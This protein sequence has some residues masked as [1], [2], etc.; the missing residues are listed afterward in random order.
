M[1]SL[2]RKSLWTLAVLLA[3]PAL[4][5]S[6]DA[7]REGP[8]SIQDNSFLVE[9]AYNQPPGVVQH[10]SA[11][12][13]DRKTQSW[14]YTFTQEWPVFSQLH[15]LSYTIP[16]ERP[17]SRLG[18]GFGDIA[19]NYR[20]QMPTGRYAA[21]A[22]APRLSALVPTGAVARG[23]GAGGTGFQANLPVSVLLT[24]SIASHSNVGMTYTHRA[25]NLA[26]ARSATRDF[27]IGQ[28]LI[29]LARPTLNFMLEAAWDSAEEVIDAGRRERSRGLFLSP[30]VR[31]A[32]NLKSGLQIV[33]G[34]AVPIGIG[35]SR[36]ERSM[37][38][39]L[40]FEHPFASTAQKD[41]E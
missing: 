29:W 3:G 13:L 25:E 34:I 10:I 7:P 19:L 8:P 23:R 41:K 6:P 40:S 18:T 14:A 31:G 20:Y 15:Q 38:F 30:G 36:G 11:F 5:Q 35:P 1:I 21:L 33:P 37:F 39:Y 26:G 24:K 4:A 28:S 22:I 16:L 27:K 17:E 9:E 12:A 32:M 2:D